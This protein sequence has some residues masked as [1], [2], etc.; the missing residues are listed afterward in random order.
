MD[1]TIDQ[2]ATELEIKM[3]YA[4]N[5]IETLNHTIY[6]QQLQIDRLQQE[7]RL[8]RTAIATNQN[9]QSAISPTSLRDEIPP[10]Y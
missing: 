6:K 9:S 1:L 7:L 2:R 10:H 5:T 8:L 3:S 4:E